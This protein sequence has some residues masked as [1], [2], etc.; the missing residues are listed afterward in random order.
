MPADTS[1]RPRNPDHA[2]H[3]RDGWLVQYAGRLHRVHVDKTEVQIYDY[4][5]RGNPLTTAMFR[6]RSSAYTQLGYRV[7]MEED[8][9]SAGTTLAFN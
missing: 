6:R 7:V 8:E 3:D 2:P 9:S 1:E 5:D 4:L